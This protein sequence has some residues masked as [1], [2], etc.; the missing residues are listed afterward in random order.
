[1]TKVL[2]AYFLSLVFGFAAILGVAPEHAQ[3][4]GLPMVDRVDAQPLLLITGR[5]AE[6]MQ[7]I[8]APF[9][10]EQMTKLASL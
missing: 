6:A 10:A 7:S 4:G 2:N 9:T 5:L 1:M 8:G 3:S